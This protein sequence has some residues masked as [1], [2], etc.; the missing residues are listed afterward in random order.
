MSGTLPDNALQLW[1]QDES[2][3]K[4]RST[5]DLD[6]MYSYFVEGATEP[7]ESIKEDDRHHCFIIFQ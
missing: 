2:N 4:F 7:I 1:L 3:D 6:G 5:E